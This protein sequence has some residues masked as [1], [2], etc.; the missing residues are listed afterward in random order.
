MAIKIE[1]RKSKITDWPFLVHAW[2]AVKGTAHLVRRDDGS[3]IGFVKTYYNGKMAVGRPTSGVSHYAYFGADGSYK[4]AA[5][6]SELP[7]EAIAR[8]TGAA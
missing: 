1:A 5:K 4:I 6:M 7:I 3:I 8:A 2:P